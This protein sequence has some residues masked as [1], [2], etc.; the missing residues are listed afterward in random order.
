M[1]I[2]MDGFTGALLA[3]ESIK[4][5]RVLLHGAG[6]CRGYVAG[7]S[8]KLYPR[9]DFTGTK[10]YDIPYFYG[11]P[12][13]PCTYVDEQD[14]I[15]GASKK[16]NGAVNVVNTKKDGLTVIINTP[17]AALIG[18]DHAAILEANGLSEQFL[19]IEESLIS[20]PVGSGF[21]RTFGHV[22]EWLDLKETEHR[23][24]TVNLLGISIMDK[25]WKRAVKELT[26]LLE[27]VGLEVIATPQAGSSLDD[28]R[29]SAKASLNIVIHPEYGLKTAEIYQ[30]RC[31]IPYFVW[32]GGAPIGFGNI[33]DWITAVAHAT[34]CDPAKALESIAKDRRFVFD[35]LMSS[36]GRLL[37]AKGGDYILD[38]DAS[39]VLP[40]MKWFYE[41]LQ[42]VPAHIR[43]REDNYQPIHDNIIAFLDKIGFPEVLDNEMPEYADVVISDGNWARVMKGSDKCS[44][45]IDI[46]HPNNGKF[47]IMPRPVM[48]VNGVIYIL[49]CLM[50]NFYKR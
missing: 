45:G 14:Y 6:G 19:V 47:D 50:N 7:Q 17:G 16:V 23:P 31:N 24:K 39:E 5:A 46:K 38:G 11:S 27:L 13:I 43:I 30:D 35:L 4:D 34:D 21:D 40:I 28:I 20:T 8:N 12:R 29:E 15:L 26:E 10:E 42:M 3:V 49:D 18:D 2:D 33:E 9:I 41:Y 32:E 22:V 25:D 44:V 37:S 48:G 36:R 1:K